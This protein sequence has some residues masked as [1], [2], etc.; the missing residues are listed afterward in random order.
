MKK[1]EVMYIPIGVPTFHLESAQIEF[2]RSIELIKNYEEDVIVPQEMLLSIDDLKAFMAGKNPD[3]IIVQNI[4]FAHSAYA[5][6]IFKTIKNA[7]VLLWTLEEPV[8]DGGRLRL[9]SLT[10]AFSAGFAFKA[11]REDNL[12][13][14]V[15]ST[16]DESVKKTLSACIKASRVKHSMNGMNLAMIGHTPPGFGFGR[17]L[18]LE[19]ASV[20]GVNLLAIES[21]ELTNLAKHLKDDAVSDEN[22]LANQKLVGLDKTDKK[23]KVDFLKLL[24]VYKNYIKENNI[25]AIASRCWPDFFTEYGTPV[26]GVLGMLNDENVAAACEADAYGALS[27]YIGDRLTN[28]PTY[29]GDPVSI[30]K[31]E[32]TITF[33]H[34][35]TSAC[36]LARKD[37]GAT[38]GVHPNRKIGPTMEFGL[39]ASQHATVFRI[40]RKPDGSFRMFITKGEILDKPQQFLGTSMVVKVTPNVENLIKDLVR[41]GFE[42]HYI[43]SYDDITTELTILSEMLNLEIIKY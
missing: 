43:V 7:D 9:N 14:M 39:K 21:R 23:N 37:T 8:I 31:E 38:V 30:D 18:D 33:W 36:S 10:G 6:E 19:M 11:M 26:C 24:K 1:F 42:P 13:Y 40:G 4:T 29:L 20:F 3:L 17:A 28:K 22:N 16:V 35:G 15:G 25:K 2:E 41:E 32:N 5:T 34:C 27:M 12:Q